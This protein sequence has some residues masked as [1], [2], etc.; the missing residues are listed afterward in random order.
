MISA[1]SG[2]ATVSPGG[3][4]CA[5]HSSLPQEWWPF[6]FSLS[7]SVAESAVHGCCAW[8]LLWDNVTASPPTS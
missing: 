2:H 1:A 7:Q 3:W 8:R 6:V 5:W 4:E